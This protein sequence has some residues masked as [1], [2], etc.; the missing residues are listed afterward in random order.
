MKVVS[1]EFNAFYDL[2]DSDADI[3]VFQAA[4]GRGRP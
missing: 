2:L 1:F 3:D 4:M